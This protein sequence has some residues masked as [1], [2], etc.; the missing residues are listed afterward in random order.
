MANGRGWE[1]VAEV[2]E[3][4]GFAFCVGQERGTGGGYEV[5]VVPLKVGQTLFKAR[6]LIVELI[7]ARDAREALGSVGGLS[8]G[9]RGVLCVV[10][11]VPPFIGGSV[12]R[13]GRASVRGVVIAVTWCA[14]LVRV[15][16][17]MR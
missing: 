16:E 1:F 13:V 12:R 5:C 3:R 9:R 17:W 4:I 14:F 6:E 15:A 2:P 10:Q 8:V 11:R 7:G